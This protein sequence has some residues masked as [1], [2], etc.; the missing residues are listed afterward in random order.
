MDEQMLSDVPRPERVRI[1]AV[2]VTIFRSHRFFAGDT[3][4]H[5]EDNT[6]G[7]AAGK[8]ESDG[9]GREGARR[10]G[11]RGDF[12]SAIK[13]DGRAGVRPAKIFSLRDRLLFPKSH[14]V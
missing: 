5:P 10:M 8:K 1:P 12:L 6:A 13:R 7:G 14:S 11:K 9:G 4:Q 2:F 3:I